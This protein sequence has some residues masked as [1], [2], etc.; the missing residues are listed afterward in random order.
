M[1]Y[2]ILMI[3]NPKAGRAKIEKY[4]EEI[5]EKFERSNNYDVEIRYTTKENN[6]TNIIKNYDDDYDIIIVCG[7]DGTLNEAIEGLH[8]IEK[9]VFVGYIPVG[10][11][12][13]FAKSLKVS[14]DVFDIANNL[15]KYETKN[16]DVGLF[17]D[18]TF[19]YVASIGIFSKT[20]YKTSSK[21]KNKMGRIAYFFLGAQEVFS[22]KSFKLKIHSGVNVIEDEFLYGSISNSKYIGGFNLFKNENVE[23]DDGEFEAIFVRKPSNIFRTLKLLLKALRGNLNDENIYYFKTSEIEIESTEE[24]EWSIDGEYSGKVKN[25]KISNLNKY[26]EYILPSTTE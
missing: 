9:K 10:T 4:A 15:N 13:D 18:R 11:T 20:S 24:T 16:V 7:G 19:N 1:K 3:V 14:F 26:I 17:N 25:I 6:A 21:L 5:K 8:K 2:K 22:H 23:L 12:N